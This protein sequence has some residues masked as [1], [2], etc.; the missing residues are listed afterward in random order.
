MYSS[1]FSSAL[2]EKFPDRAA[3]F[4]RHAR[5]FKREL[6][7][8]D[9]NVKKCL[10]RI[11]TEKRKLVLNHDSFSYFASEYGLEIVGTLIPSQSTEAQPS[12]GE[13]DELTDRIRSQ[14][15]AAVFTEASASTKLAKAVAAD[16]GVG[17]AGPLYS[18]SLGAA[19]SEGSSWLAAQRNNARKVFEGLTGSTCQLSSI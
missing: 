12:A 16:A 18:D 14:E 13:I 5:A 8:L 2:S 7:K 17:T 11:P 19:D 10:A 3:S 6:R 15:I 9:K 4:E 1:P